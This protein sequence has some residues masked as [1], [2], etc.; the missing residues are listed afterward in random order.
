MPGSDDVTASILL[1]D[2]DPSFSDFIAAGLG[3][4]GLP[5]TVATTG[6]SGID[7]LQ[8]H[9]YSLVLLDLLLPDIDGLEVLRRMKD[10]APLPP[11]IMLSGLGTVR[12]AVDAVRLGAVDFLEKPLQ[13]SDLA[14]TVRSNLAVAADLA[15]TADSAIHDLVRWVMTVVVAETDTRTID[16]WARRA[17]TS[18]PTIFARCAKAHLKAKALLDLGRLLRIARMP[19]PRPKHIVDSLDNKDLRTVGCLLG[20]ARISGDDLQR[21]DP[22][23]LLAIQRLVSSEQF[24]AIFRTAL[25]LHDQTRQ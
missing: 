23:R 8:R 13:V 17:G 22:A 14:D 7:A 25:R 19:S 11:V 12:S 16:A 3:K 1:I 20:R 24:T 6:L 9:R 4:A 2:D 10:K 18:S 5:T 15:D 21:A